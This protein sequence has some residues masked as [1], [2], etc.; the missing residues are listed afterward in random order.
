MFAMYKKN[1]VYTFM[2][3]GFVAT[4]KKTS[5]DK[6]FQVGL[7]NEFYIGRRLYFFTSKRKGH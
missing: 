4:R 3:H 5:D 2:F 1:I 7:K 6:S